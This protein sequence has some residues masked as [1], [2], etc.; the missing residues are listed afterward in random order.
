MN[1]TRT[2]QSSRARSPLQTAS[3][4]RAAKRMPT[5]GRRFLAW[6]LEVAILTASVAL[7]F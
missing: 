3:T 6:S 1:S 2:K 5:L 7:P 4:S